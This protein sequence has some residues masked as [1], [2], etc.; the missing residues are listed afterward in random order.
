MSE[1][2]YPIEAIRK[3][4]RE[5]LTGTE[6]L[7]LILLL[8]YLN[9]KE[10]YVSAARIANEASLS[11]PTVERAFRKFK[12]LKIM[13]TRKIRRGT[14]F[15]HLKTFDLTLI[16][17]FG[18]SSVSTDELP[19]EFSDS[20]LDFEIDLS[21]PCDLPPFTKPIRCPEMTP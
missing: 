18:K 21:L 13:K 16:R 12:Q 1:K 9:C 8:D 7:T 5:V 3:I 19:L 10:V 11:V 6:K 2:F 20:A 4:P 14:V 17:E 15:L